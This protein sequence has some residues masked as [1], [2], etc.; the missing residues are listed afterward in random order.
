MVKLSTARMTLWNTG[1][2]PPELETVWEEANEEIPNWPGFHRL[3]IG[4]D[5]RAALKGIEAEFPPPSQMHFKR[6]AGR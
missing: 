3:E 4:T 5:E 2:I 1:K 6:I